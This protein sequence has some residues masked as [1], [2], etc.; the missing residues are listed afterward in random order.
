[1]PLPGGG[2]DKAG[3]RY[4]LRWTVRQFIRLLTGDAVWIELEPIGEEG[5][6]VEFCLQRSDG[7]IEAHQ[8]KR[9]QAGRGHWTIADL[10]RVGVLEGVRKH[11][12]EGN[13]DFVFVSTQAPK[14]LPELR[15]RA[16]NATD[17]SA[18]QAALSLPLK[19]DLDTL[20]SRLGLASGNDT[21]EALAHTHWEPI[22]ERTLS[23]TVLAL[24][25]A[26]LT[27]DPQAALGVLALFALDAIHRRVTALELWDV[28]GRHGIEPSDVARD[29]NL[30]ARLRQCQEDYF[31]S[32][33]F[34]I[35]DLV[36]PRGEADQISATFLDPVRSTKSIFLLGTAGAGKTS[37]T[38][39]IV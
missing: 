16:G 7:R 30:V 11:A 20:Q 8:V 37:V 21:L 3:N 36:L 10:A 15:D 1:M 25:D 33:E 18:F 35:G 31:N 24:L 17:A 32:Q 26:H 23:D 12:V 14:S 13:A 39:Q 28:L 27:G 19:G 22:G 6:R 38:G 2:A 34:G 5:E 29:R 9:Q 4:E